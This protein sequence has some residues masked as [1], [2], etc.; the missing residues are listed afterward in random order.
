MPCEGV[1]WV[2]LGSVVVVGVGGRVGEGRVGVGRG[3]VV[4]VG[5]GGGGAS[6]VEVEVRLADVFSLLLVEVSELVVP[7][8]GGP[9]GIGGAVV[10]DVA[11]V[12]EVVGRSVMSGPAD[13][14]RWE[15]ATIA[16]VVAKTV[17]TAMPDAASITRRF[18]RAS[19]SSSSN[20]SIGAPT[21]VG[22]SQSP[23]GPGSCRDL[24]DHTG[25]RIRP[26]QPPVM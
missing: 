26:D 17:A 25:G 12:R 1:G 16:A 2:G 20:G 5:G 9:G 11:L 19:G 6:V 14:C 21:R 4:V 3:V 15:P 18:G 23:V 10:Y 8:I 22:L 7:V 13:S 24:A